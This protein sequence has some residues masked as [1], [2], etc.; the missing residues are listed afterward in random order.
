MCELYKIYYS[1][2]IDDH[3]VI[4]LIECKAQQELL[5]KYCPDMFRARPF[6]FYKDKSECEWCLKDDD[7]DSETERGDSDSDTE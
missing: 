7:N 1:C 6:A 4:G 3:I 5:Q 2:D